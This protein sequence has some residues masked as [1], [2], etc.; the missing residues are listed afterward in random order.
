MNYSTNYN[1]N[2]PE[3]NEQFNL[4]HWN[5]NTKAIDTTMKANENKSVDNA[6]R[7]TALERCVT[8]SNKATDIANTSSQLYKLMKAI[9]PVGSLYWSSKNTNPST[10][11]G[12]TWTQIKDKFVLACGDTYKTTGATGGNASIKLTVA[13]LPSHNH[14]FTPSGTVKSTFTGTSHS[15]TFTP[16]GSISGGAY[17]FTGTKETTSLDGQ[18]SHTYTAPNTPENKLNPDR[19]SYAVRGTS[20]LSTSYEGKH[21]HSFIPSGSISVTTNPSFSGT[22]GT[23]GSTTQGGTVASSFTGTSSSTSSVGSATAINILPP[24]IVKY[25]WE[26]TA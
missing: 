5:A 21:A 16:S 11:F 15:H 2:M 8:A 13:N 22:A 18:H 9:Y 23:T 3:R 4:D 12:G 7:A 14:T 17:K 6:N 26:R 10:L 1:L 25:C 24:Y 20:N 19:G